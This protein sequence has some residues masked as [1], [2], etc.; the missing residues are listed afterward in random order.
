MGVTRGR[1]TAKAVGGSAESTGAHH[2]SPEQASVDEAQREFDT[3][4]QMR[5][6]GIRA[7]IWN[8]IEVAQE[9]INSVNLEVSQGDTCACLH[10]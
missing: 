2:G 1:T 8:E 10:A 3:I 9:D 4:L 6:R 5:R 7:M